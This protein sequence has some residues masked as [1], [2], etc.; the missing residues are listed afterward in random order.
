YIVINAKDSVWILDQHAVHERILYEK[1]KMKHEPK[2]KQ[3]LL[4]PEIIECEP[5]IYEL[6]VENIA[7]FE[8]LNISFEDFGNKQI[9]LRQ[10]PLEFTDI[11]FKEFISLFL[12]QIL[13]SGVQ[14]KNIKEFDFKKLQQLSCKAAIKAGKKMAR[15]EVQSLIND[16]VKAPD[17]YTCPHGR[18]LFIKMTKPDL[19]KMFGRQ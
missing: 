6:A 19:E 1:L 5:H 4:V 15:L 8:K 16:F 7:L 9:I 14:M 3:P 13:E 18:P 10:V 17:N 11:S 12:N 2:E